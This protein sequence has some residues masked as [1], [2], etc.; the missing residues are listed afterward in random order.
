MH[1]YNMATI[2]RIRTQSPAVI[3][4]S[5]DDTNNDDV[6]SVIVLHDSNMSEVVRNMK[7]VIC[8][9]VIGNIRRM[10]CC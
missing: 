3:G 5:I 1:K 8:Q 4:Q 2:T 6:S 9:N 10:I 7:Y